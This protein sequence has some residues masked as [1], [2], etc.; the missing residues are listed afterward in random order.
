[1]HITTFDHSLQLVSCGPKS[2]KSCCVDS[3]GAGGA[4]A[5]T[6][7]EG[8]EKGQSLIFA[9]W[10]LANTASTSEFEKLS[11]AL[12]TPRSLLNKLAGLTVLN[13]VKQASW[14]NRDLIV[15]S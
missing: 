13:T 3:G 1:M 12:L 2:V 15:L 8:S 10:S 7:F 4:R 5:P 6:E 14:F 9:F 11:T